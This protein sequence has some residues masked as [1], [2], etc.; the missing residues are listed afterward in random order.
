MGG[1][2]EEMNLKVLEPL[3]YLFKDEVKKVAKKLKFPDKIIWRQPFHGP[4][5]SIRVIGP[6]DRDRLDILREADEIITQEIKKNS[7]FKKVW[8]SFCIL[9]PIMT[10]GVMGDSRTYDFALS[11]RL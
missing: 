2:P 7:L 3:K 4:G 8:Q 6:V 5:L 10:V 11:L 9:F 1:L